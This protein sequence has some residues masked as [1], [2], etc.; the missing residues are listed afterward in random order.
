MKLLTRAEEYVLLAVWRLG[1]DA[2]SLKL[3]EAIH[4]ISG[5]KWSLGTIYAPLE[6]L[7]KRGY[8]ISAF[9]EAVPE[10]GGRQ[11]RIYHLTSEGKEALVRIKKVHET[12]WSG[13]P[14]LSLESE[15]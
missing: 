1:E 15:V 10:R 7:E 5:E 11:R 8:I 9:S 14:D 3:Q 6:R 4:R 13:L 12:F 2:Y